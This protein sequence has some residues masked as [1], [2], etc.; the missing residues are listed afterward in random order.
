MY[1]DNQRQTMILI[2]SEIQSQVALSVDASLDRQTQQL[3]VM[4]RAEMARLYEKLLQTS[5]GM[6]REA[7]AALLEAPKSWMKEQHINLVQELKDLLGIREG[8][9]LDTGS[10]IAL[11]PK[12][13]AP[14]D[15]TLEQP[16]HD[17][18]MSSRRYS[19]E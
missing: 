12:F 10:K 9:P 8:P 6:S 19:R 17:K 5:V 18:N 16:S 3:L 15:T 7:E 13:E 1:A 11:N 4:N 14:E 2:S